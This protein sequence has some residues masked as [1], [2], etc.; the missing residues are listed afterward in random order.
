MDIKWRVILLVH[1]FKYYESYQT[2]TS[3]GHKVG[4]LDQFSG[5]NYYDL[6]RDAY[7]LG[8]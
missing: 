6:E 3:T 5:I 2:K 1:E 7:L 4:P 8:Q